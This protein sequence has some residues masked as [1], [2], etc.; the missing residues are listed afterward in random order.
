ML[1]LSRK[2]SETIC[3]D[4]GR[5]VVTVVDIRGDRVRIGVTTDKSISVHRGEVQAEIDD[6]RDAAPDRGTFTSH[7]TGQEVP[8]P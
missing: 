2:N 5:I 1:V 4:G 7:S 8:L 6:E 3:I